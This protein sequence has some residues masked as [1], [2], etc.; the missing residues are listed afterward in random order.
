MSK[1][2]SSLWLRGRA[3]NL[4]EHMTPQER[5]VWRLLR[6][7]ELGALNWRRQSLFGRYVA[8]FISHPAR[9]V[10]EIDGAQHG[11]QTQADHDKERTAWFGAQGYRVLRF[12]NCDTKIAQNEIWLAIQAAAQATPA[13]VRMERWRFED[14]RRVLQ[15]NSSL[16]LDGGGREAAGGGVSAGGE[17]EASRG[18]TG[19]AGGPHPLSRATRDCSPI[20]GERK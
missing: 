7:G 12:W 16:P 13:R 17:G 6:S 19:N 15:A 2:I 10:I 11:E 20:E 5:V 9:L 3:K 18:A 1:R 8:D 4:R 14:R